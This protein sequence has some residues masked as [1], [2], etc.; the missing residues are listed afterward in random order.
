MASVTSATNMDIAWPIAQERTTRTKI[1]IRTMENTKE[2]FM[3]NVIIVVN[4][5]IML[6]TVGRKRTRA[7]I[8]CILSLQVKKAI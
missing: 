8:W 3:A 4:Q 5:D 7:N 6:R 1:M 2:R